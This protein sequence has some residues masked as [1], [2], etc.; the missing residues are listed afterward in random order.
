MPRKT[1]DQQATR[2]IKVTITVKLPVEHAYTDS[3][4]AETLKIKSAY[5]EI[6]VVRVESEGE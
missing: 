2:E 1:K 4:I 3:E 5:K 6:K